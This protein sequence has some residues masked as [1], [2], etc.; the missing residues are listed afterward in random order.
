MYVQSAFSSCHFFLKHCLYAINFSSTTQP[1]TCLE[2]FLILFLAFAI[3]AVI[4]LAVLLSQSATPTEGKS[5]SINSVKRA[6]GVALYER[7]GGR[8]TQSLKWSKAATVI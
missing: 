5:R 8:V 2:K 6:G 3:V 1:R 7:C 4:V